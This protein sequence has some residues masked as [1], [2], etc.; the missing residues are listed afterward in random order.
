MRDQERDV[1]IQGVKGRCKKDRIEGGKDIIPLFGIFKK[2]YAVKISN[3]DVY[4][5]Y[6]TWY[7][8]F[9]QSIYGYF[10]WSKGDIA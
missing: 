4:P 1:C 8:Q 3:L 6:F 7:V 5:F 2:V 10:I 9:W